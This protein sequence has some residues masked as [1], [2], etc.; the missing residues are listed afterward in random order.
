MKEVDM[1][2]LERCPNL[3]C[4]SD[5]HS[6]KLHS[7][8]NFVS[9]TVCGVRGP[10]FDKHSEDAI[11]GWNLL[12][13]KTYEDEP[14][15][16]ENFVYVVEVR[17]RWWWL[18]DQYLVKARDYV[19]TIL[20]SSYLGEHTFYMEKDETILIKGRKWSHKVG[21]PICFW[22]V[23]EKYQDKVHH[24]SYIRKRKS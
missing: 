22:D 18:H 9:C 3:E 19:D 14:K 4:S 7:N 15:D 13:R 1:H 5:G 11:R 10:M 2:Q 17:R 12:P 6:L 16:I 23:A 8:P 24:Y 20:D 21:D